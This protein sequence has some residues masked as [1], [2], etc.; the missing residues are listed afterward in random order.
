MVT[1]RC[2]SNPIGKIPRYR[3]RGKDVSSA[4]IMPAIALSDHTEMIFFV[5]QISLPLSLIG[6]VCGSDPLRKNYVCQ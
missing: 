5:Y 1:N 6:P 4:N 3:P 2:A